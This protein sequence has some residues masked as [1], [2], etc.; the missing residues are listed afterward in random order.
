MTIEELEAE[1]SHLRRTL[2]LR[3]ERERELT[4]ALAE[5]D[6][7]YQQLLTS[8]DSYFADIRATKKSVRWLLSKARG[9][10]EAL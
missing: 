2:D 9:E 6:G 8:V 1:V 3:I 7:R 4:T 5:L 10:D